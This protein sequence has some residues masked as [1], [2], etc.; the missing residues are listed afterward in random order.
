MR[1]PFAVLIATILLAGCAG[2]EPEEVG[3]ASD[4]GNA[5]DD[6]PVETGV[7]QAPAASAAAPGPAANATAN[8]TAPPRVVKVPVDLSGNLGAWAMACQ[9][10]VGCNGL[11]G[12]E[13]DRVF[14]PPLPG[15]PV[16]WNLTLE[17]TS[18]D[19]TNARLVLGFEACGD[20]GCRWMW[21]GGTSPL[22][23][24]GD[25]S[26]VATEPG[27]RFVVYVRAFAENGP[28]ETYAAT[29]VAFTIRGGID[30]L[31]S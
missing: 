7:A 23:L 29:D 9:E 3:A 21:T 13:G 5:S 30:V 24:S 15:L 26:G 16:G 20:S 14:E 28:I 11:S 22:L 19:P 10:V 18:T 27:D 17:W 31:S 2:S 8:Q 1:L 4:G 12:L 6:A 25:R